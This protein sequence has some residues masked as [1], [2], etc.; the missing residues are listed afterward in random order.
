MPII[1][2]HTKM[3]WEGQSSRHKPKTSAYATRRAVYGTNRWTKL[4]KRFLSQSEN[5]LCVHCKKEGKVRPATEAGHVIPIG[6]C[7]D[8]FDT[9]NLEPTCKLHNVKKAKKDNLKHTQG[10]ANP[11][12]YAL[13]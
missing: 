10:G 3:Y 2:K 5:A 9:N 4:A 12:V 13:P 6:K 1:P 11:Y 8:P 7:I